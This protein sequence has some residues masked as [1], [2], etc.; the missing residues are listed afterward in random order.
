MGSMLCLLSLT[1]ACGGDGDDISSPQTPP[2]A[3][4]GT[5]CTDSTC[6]LLTAA[7]P[8]IGLTQTSFRFCIPFSGGTLRPCGSRSELGINNTGGGTLHWTA[9]KTGTWLRISPHYGTTLSGM[10][11]GMQVWVVGTDVPPGSYVGRIRIWATGATNSPQTVLVYFT[12]R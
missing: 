1:A 4:S 10:Q 2:P 6:G 5:G 8:T 7:T 11:S 9:T 12:K 3:V